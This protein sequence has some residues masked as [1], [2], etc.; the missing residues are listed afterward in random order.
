MDCGCLVPCHTGLE[1]ELV[2]GSG[3]EDFLVLLNCSAVFGYLLSDAG[4]RV[5]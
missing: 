1:S 2:A 3:N 4:N 5:A